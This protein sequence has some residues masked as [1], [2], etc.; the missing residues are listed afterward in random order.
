MEQ[1]TTKR[2]PCRKWCTAVRLVQYTCTYRYVH[3]CAVLY[4][5]AH[6]QSGGKK[7]PGSVCTICAVCIAVKSIGTVHCTRAR[8]RVFSVCFWW[9]QKVYPRFMSFPVSVYCTGTHVLYA[10]LAG[11][12]FA[13]YTVLF[14]CI[15]IVSE[16]AL[17]NRTAAFG[18]GATTSSA[19]YHQNN[20]RSTT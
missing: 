2:A 17:Q 16:I 10:G 9:P 20:S 19:H 13:V 11:L 1:K 15:I 6:V 7:N 8:S 5:T 12:R 18:P 3:T 14:F 4:C